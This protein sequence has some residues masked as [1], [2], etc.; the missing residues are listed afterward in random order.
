MSALRDRVLGALEAVKDPCSVATR[1]PM[2]IVDL[3]LLVGLEIDEQ[4]GAVSIVLRPT[5]LGCVLM[6]SIMQASE[7][8]ARAVEGVHEVQVRLDLEAEWDPGSMSPRAA[9][10][11][12]AARADARRR[13]SLQ[14]YS[15][16]GRA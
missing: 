10:R 9:E 1:R 16:A 5:T 13:L 14:P 6:G 7:E 8:Q 11:L 2:S 15:R 4:A 3:G 12:A